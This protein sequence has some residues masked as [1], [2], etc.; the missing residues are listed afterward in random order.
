MAK[1]RHLCVRDR[2]AYTTM[3]SSN[4]NK[5]AQSLEQLEQEPKAFL[6]L[7]KLR[8]NERGREN[9]KEECVCVC[10][11]FFVHILG[12]IQRLSTQLPWCVPAHECSAYSPRC[13]SN[14]RWTA[15]LSILSSKISHDVIMNPSWT[16]LC[17]KALRRPSLSLPHFLFHLSLLHALFLPFKFFTEL[18][19]FCFPLFHISVFFNISLLLSMSLFSLPPLSLK[20]TNSFLFLASV[21]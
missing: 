3:Y 6:L 20:H 16:H 9:K 10:V 15:L 19:L 17:Q 11:L 5:W 2:R 1:W 18:P 13:L 4:K 7:N 8:E 12:C 21:V 14:E